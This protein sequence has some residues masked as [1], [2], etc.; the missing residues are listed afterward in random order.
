MA[1]LGEYNPILTYLPL[2]GTLAGKD[3]SGS[4]FSAVGSGALRWAPAKGAR[5]NY[6]INPRFAND[7][8]GWGVNGVGG[9]VTRVTDARFAGGAALRVVAT[10]SQPYNGMTQ[11]GSFVPNIKDGAFS[12]VTLSFDILVESGKFASL[13]AGV[14]GLDAAGG[15]VSGGGASGTFSVS[16]LNTLERKSLTLTFAA[17][18][19][20]T[21]KFIFYA[22]NGSNDATQ[23][24]ISNIVV[25][26]GSVPN[27]TYFDGSYPGC[28]FF[29]PRTGQL[30]SAWTSP[31]CNQ[32]TAWIEEG[33]T[34]LLLNPS[35]EHGTSSTGIAAIG[36]GTVTYTKDTKTAYLGS[37]SAKLVCD[38]TETNQGVEFSSATGLNITSAKTYIGSVYVR[39]SGTV[40]ALTRCSY[41][42]ES[43]EDS[44]SQVI[45][46]TNAWQRI[47]TNTRATNTGKT[48]DSVKLVV[49]TNSAQAVTFYV[50]C[51]QVEEKAFC[52]SYCDGSLGTGY[53][54]SGTAH[55][56][57]ST[58]TGATIS[59]EQAGRIS[60]LSGALAFR[61]T[62]KID[63]GAEETILTCGTVGAATDYL[64]LGIDASDHVYME[65][66]SNGAGAKR[67]TGT[68][69][70]AVDTEYFLYADWTGTAIRLSVD[71]GTLATDTRDAVQGSWGAGDLTLSAATGS[72]VYNGFATFDRVL[73]TYET[74]R[75]YV[76]PAWSLSTLAVNAARRIRSQF[77][78]RPY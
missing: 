65:W 43:S 57:A 67:V 18:H 23:F 9:S 19:L 11:Q 66:S 71:N 21:S 22:S 4:N 73:T 7:G 75:L 16:G 42:D 41:T 54:W 36:S 8:N 40:E 47:S 44:S 20:L 46:L 3:S 64:E 17:N 1:I 63:T 30:G 37:A 77:Q 25:E 10:D 49:R 69:A 14:S 68:D 28:N 26:Y 27:A 6:A 48:L 55:A 29:D 60:S 45:A 39:G 32:L 52:T 31:S 51:A 15:F 62:R 38:G 34:N 78:L 50:D 70:I 24:L 35:V 61:Y 33:T 72:V 2:N 76:A 53:S 12:Q 74:T 13:T 59:F 58:R 56:S 5:I